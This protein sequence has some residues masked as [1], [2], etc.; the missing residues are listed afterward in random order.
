MNDTQSQ[1]PAAWWAEL[2]AVRSDLGQLRRD[3][4]RD[5]QMTDADAEIDE[6]RIT[7]LEEILA[8]PWPKRIAVRRRLARD[9]R[10][11]IANVQ[12]D[13]FAEKRVETVASGWIRPLRDRR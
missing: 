9:L 11:S 1:P 10:Q 4:V 12:G 13:S 3:V 2:D 7:A 6:L 8:T 5:S